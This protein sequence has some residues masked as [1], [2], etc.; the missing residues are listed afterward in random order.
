MSL[1]LLELPRGGRIRAV[2][3]IGA[4]GLLRAVGIWAQPERARVVLEATV[5]QVAPAGALRL[6]GGDVRLSTTARVTGPDGEKLAADAIGA[7]SRLWL[8]GSYSESTGFV[9]DEVRLCRPREFEIEKIAGPASH[10]DPERQRFQIAGFTIVTSERT[11]YGKSGSGDDGD[12]S[13]WEEREEEE[14]T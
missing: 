14:L 3:T 2:G 5:E 13:E 7:G 4:D 8:G 12:E 6:L 9:A 1:A 11:L 10:I